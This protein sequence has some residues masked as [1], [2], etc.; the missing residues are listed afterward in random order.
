MKK[1]KGKLPS[2][3]ELHKY[4]KHLYTNPG[5]TGSFGG[6]EAFKRS[7][8]DVG[9]YKISNKQI[10]DFLR[11]EDGYTINRSTRKT[12]PTQKVVVGAMFQEHQADLMDVASLKTDNDGV[13]FLLCVIDIF[14]RFGVV[15]CLEDK[16]AKTLDKAIR[17]IY[18]STTKPQLLVT[19]GGVFLS[20]VN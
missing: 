5:S 14:S 11:S 18:D 3:K 15:Q 6:R 19:D 17:S 2:A 9:K 13:R 1:R 16:S 4:M 12:F 8:E 10:D 7:I 20:Q